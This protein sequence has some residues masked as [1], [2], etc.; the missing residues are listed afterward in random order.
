[1]INDTKLPVSISSDKFR[2]I[3]GHFISG[4]T[5]VTAKH[6]DKNFGVTASSVASVS[7]DPPM[8]L[9]C[10]NQNTGTQTAISE[11][12]KFAVH[13][14]KETQAG[15]A[16]KFAKP[17]SDKFKD[18]SYSDGDLSVPIIDDTLAVVE[19][20]VAYEVKAGTH[21]VFI[22]AV[23]K[24]HSFDEAPLAYFRGEFGSFLN[25][26]RPEASSPKD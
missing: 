17:N 5:I 7:L 21:S 20:K 18:V 16:L 6:H 25:S 19:C 14:L 2:N 8:L 10:I 1:M 12:K 9:V 15:L 13:I 23:Q 4:V 3:I 26:R 22:G 11:T 24:G